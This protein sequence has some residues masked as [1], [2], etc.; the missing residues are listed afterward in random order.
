MNY[1]GV[2]LLNKP[3]GPTSHDMIY[4]MRRIFSTKKVGHTG[5]LDPL[6]TGVLP[7][8]VGNAT[9]ASD[10]LLSE[11]KEY[12]AEIKFGIQT[13][14]GDI[15]G[16]VTKNLDVILDENKLKS[17]LD[18][19]VGEMMQVPPMYSAKKINGK[20][21]YELARNGQVV[22]RP[23]VPVTI[24]EIELLSCNIEE[25]ICKIRVV[26]S[27][28]TYIR[29]LCEDIAKS[30]ETVGCMSSLCRTRSGDFLIHDAYTVEQ[31]RMLAQEGI[32]SDALIPTPKLFDYKE[33]ILSQKQSHRFKNGVFV[34]HPQI[35][36]GCFYK[37]FDSEGS[38]MAVAVC[39]DG[40]LR[41]KKSFLK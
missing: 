31:L 27:K 5:T 23:P 14:T 16:Q 1:N 26:C 37:V 21:L 35:A 20:K 28:G 7:I 17:T 30:M 18:G 9:K 10:M 40:R 33:V 22:E 34:S 24:F 39:V 3:Q 4:E 11:K 13:D 29:S 25:K 38:F 41:I 15:T 8:C 36:E 19:F 12:V 32:L 2:V 6:A